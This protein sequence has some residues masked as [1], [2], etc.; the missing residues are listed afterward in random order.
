MLTYAEALAA[1]DALP[2]ESRTEML[3]THAAVGRVLATSVVMDRDQPGFDRATM[4]GFAIALDGKR[5]TFNIVSTVLAGQAHDGE[6]LPGQAVRIMTGAPCPAG[7]TVVQVEKTET[8]E[9]SVRVTD[10]A[11]LQPA[12]NIAKRG[13]DAHEGDLILAARTRL[14]APTVATA[15]MAGSREIEVYSCPTLGIVTTG[16]EVGGAGPAGIHDSNGPL[17][18]AFAAAGGC[19]AERRHAIDEAEILR[20]TLAAAAENA[21]IVITVGGV[22]MGTHDLVPGAAID[23]GFVPVFHKVA[24]QPGKPVFVAQH[25]DGTVFLGLPGNPVSVLATA[26]LFGLP[27][28]GRFLGGWQPTWLSMPLTCDHVHRGKRHLFLP[29]VLGDGGVTPIPWN[30]S[31]DLLAAGAADGLIDLAAGSC[32]RA[33]D[34]VRFLPYLG[35]PAGERG[36]IPRRGAAGDHC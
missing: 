6:L 13:E 11:A 33:G 34:R 23:L 7:T 4:D 27:L 18:Q 24:I 8:N 14:S 1:L 36:L 25:A 35:H 9:S 3:A 20:S 15:A 19:P 29:S 21:D 28:I 2:I 10:K 5:D 31:G 22:S 30:G 32:N 12:K 17:L 26:H 16:D